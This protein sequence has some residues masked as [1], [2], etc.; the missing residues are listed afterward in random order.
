M[1]IYL[2]SFKKRFL[3][4]LFTLMK[5]LNALLLLV[6]SSVISF[7]THAQEFDWVKSL[8][9]TTT[10]T[11]VAPYKSVVDPS[12]NVYT[13][14]YFD[15]TIDF[16]PGPGTYN[17]TTAGSYDIYIVKLDASGNLVWAR[18]IGG[19][20]SDLG[21]SIAID[22]SG[23]V[24][25]TGSFVGTV[26]FD[27]GSGVFNMTSAV[28]D[29]IFVSKLDAMGN[30]V[31]AKSIAGAAGLDYGFD[32]AVSA[33]GNV[34]TTG[35]FR[36][37]A[38]FDPGNDTF[39]LNSSAAND[40]FVSKLDASGNF[41]WAKGIG[42]PG[43]TEDRGIAITLDA[44]EN[45]YTTGYFQG[46][47]DFDPGVG[48]A[49]MTSAGNKDIFYSKLD[50]A[51]NFV[52]AKRTGGTGN[53]ASY[54]LAI[55]I[56]GN[57]YATG[58]YEGTVDFDPGAGTANLTSSGS[59]DIYVHKLDASGNYIW[60]KS[61]GGTSDE[62]GNA[63]D[64]D[65]AG[66]VYV[67]GY[68]R[69]TSDFDPGSGV[70]NLVSAGSRELFIAKL[71]VSGNLVWADSYGSTANE[72][73]TGI[74]LG[75]AESIYT[76]GYFSS[77]VD[78][79][80]GP[81]IVNLTAPGTR[82]PVFI[83]KLNQ[84]ASV[85]Y[86][87]NITAC[88]PFTWRDGNTY[89]ATQTGNTYT[90]DGAVYGGCDST[91]ILNLTITANT[92][93]L[94]SLSQSDNTCFGSSDGAASVN[95]ATGG[96]GNYTYDW[97]PGNPSGD[98]TTSASGLPAG[99]W[100]CTAT[101]ANG[102]AATQSFSITE[103]AQ[104][105]GGFSQTNCDSYIWNAQTY[106]VSGTYT[107]ILTAANGCDSTVT[108]NLTITNST[109]GIDVITAC[110]SYTW[111]DGN[112][113][114]SS[115]NS[116]THLLTNSAGCDSTVTLNLTINTAPTMTATDNGSGTITAS[117]AA[118]YQWINCSTNTPIAGA[119]SGAYSPTA[120]GTY[121]VIGYSAQQCADTS[122]CVLINYL[123][124]AETQGVVWNIMPNPAGNQVMVTFNANSAKLIIRDVQGKPVSAT[125][126]H[127]G[128]TVSLEELSAG[129][130]FFELITPEGKTVKRVMK[131]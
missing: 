22:A 104:I 24:Y 46:T 131:M 3:K 1:L 2:L 28:A 116:A 81:A 69:G 9:P 101:D 117:T 32:I 17:L 89:T 15:G 38:D 91:Y 10:T 72:V 37:P 53:D 121:A 103:P 18:S 82:T 127:S 108:L 19:M 20:Y 77:T 16:D 123:D 7:S 68:F 26:D 65:A 84:C 43:A 36:G 34:Y 8:T 130:Y 76:T 70:Y 93:G 33:A 96:S 114:T 99:T 45:V 48:I 12:G 4:P 59:W 124:I 98:G 42:G 63:L 125:C 41:I 126:I 90:V 85:S 31:W 5:K 92:V 112:T 95:V 29:D 40:I 106:T 67:T 118:S 57:V 50:A 62:C 122:N 97:T 79:D 64:V 14:G 120:N 66:N 128:E 110:D 87:E 86:T 49:N 13:T 73:G 52:W 44:A 105:T 107:Q 129:V 75:P 56:A 113:Y 30:F 119:T 115:N 54:G 39:Y 27:P 109:T 71:D 25:T 94:T 61:M 35:T 102:C 60:A 21:L 55:D 74:C 83:Q 78:F 88:G 111:I 58:Q 80:P 100:T 23:N 11:S 51:G 6:C 47:V